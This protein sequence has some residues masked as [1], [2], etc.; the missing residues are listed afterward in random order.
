MNKNQ[1]LLSTVHKT[2]QQS[3]IGI[4]SILDTAIHPQLRSILEQQLLEYE[5]LETEAC[6]IAV[7]PQWKQSASLKK[8]QTFAA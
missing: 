5:A 4:R 7:A 6:C 8:T 2:T 3:Q 1:I